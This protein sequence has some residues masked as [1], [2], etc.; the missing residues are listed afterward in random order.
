MNPVAPSGWAQMSPGV[1]RVRNRGFASN[2]YLSLLDEPGACVVIDPGLDLDGIEAAMLELGVR[3]V[4]VFCT[5][6][7]FDHIG[8]AA[9]LNE[10]YG[11]PV[12]LHG[13]DKQVLSRAN[14]IMMICKAEGR[15]DVPR[16]DV[17]MEDG[18]TY[19]SGSDTVSVLHTPGHTPGSTVLRFHDV[20]FTGDTLYRDSAGL[21]NFPGEDQD[22][23]RASVSRT[24]DLI[25]DSSLVCPGHGGAGPFG[26][27][28]RGNQSLRTFL[29]LPAPDI[30]QN[31]VGNDILG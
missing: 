18:A 5:H 11:A 19:L 24:W 10:R 20:V 14:F 17:V 29:G 27:I 15:I 7:H 12:H 4:A 22:A 30:E 13:G 6:A 16:V 28:K 2:T 3:P 8:S 25:P 21:V 23:L 26:A 31:G 9:A 1:W